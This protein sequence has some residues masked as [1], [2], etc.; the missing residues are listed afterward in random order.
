MH[1]SH[2]YHTPPLQFSA[3][4]S[5]H[6]TFNCASY[7]ESATTGRDICFQVTICHSACLSIQ[8]HR[9]GRWVQTLLQHQAE[10]TIV[11]LLP[12]LQSSDMQARLYL[13]RFSLPWLPVPALKCFC[14][15]LNR[16]IE[17]CSRERAACQS[18]LKTQKQKI[19]R[20]MAELQH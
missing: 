20:P 14:S 1:M 19:K 15:I 11:P 12:S 2:S 13:L 18:Q 9:V 16:L 5:Q 7:E 3:Y 4:R 10:L 8:G 17:Q 6:I